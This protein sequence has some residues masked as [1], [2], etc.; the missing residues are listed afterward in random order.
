MTVV[1]MNVAGRYG[2]KQFDNVTNIAISGNDYVLTYT[3]SLSTLTQS[4]D[5][6]YY[7]LMILHYT[8]G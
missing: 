1:V 7:D 6:R 8:E 5:R 4:Y 2:V 3:E